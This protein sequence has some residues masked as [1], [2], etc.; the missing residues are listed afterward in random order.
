MKKCGIYRIGCL[1][2][3]KIYVGQ[4]LDL[5]RRGAKHF[6]DLRKSMHHNP[7]LQRA[8]LKHGE[9]NFE[10]KILEE[11]PKE[12]LDA[13]E[14]AWVRFYR[15]TR[16]EFGYNIWSGGNGGSCHSPATRKKM[17]EARMGRK[18]GPRPLW[19][20]QK[21]SVTKKASGWSPSPEA[22]RQISK[23]L[24]G[25]IMPEETRRKISAAN[26]G[27]HFSAAARRNMGLAR[28]GIPLSLAHR[29]KLSDAAK[30]RCLRNGGRAV[31]MHFA[32]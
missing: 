8:F 10:F 15:S 28:K 29:K 16:P 5:N 24:T 9:Q 32:R 14:L 20:C 4:S 22:R 25:R 6:N 17:S 19:V 26:T 2:D 1:I 27:R 18:F 7:Y 30:A 13:L 3:G 11:S 31:I 23:T 21:I 12:M